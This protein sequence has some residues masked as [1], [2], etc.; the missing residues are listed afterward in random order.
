M[1]LQKR[2]STGEIFRHKRVGFKDELKGKTNGPEQAAGE[3]FLPGEG[4]DF[5]EESPDSD[6]L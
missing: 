3:R 5:A 1:I 2:C 6:E 4:M